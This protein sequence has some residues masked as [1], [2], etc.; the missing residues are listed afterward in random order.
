MFQLKRLAQVPGLVHGI[1][2][3]R[4]GSQSFRYVSH[5]HWTRSNRERFLEQ[6]RKLPGGN[7]LFS[8]G[9][10]VAMRPEFAPPLPVEKEILL[11]SRENRQAGMFTAGDE[12]V[13]EALVTTEPGVFLFLTIADCLPVVLFHPG[14]RILALAHVSRVTAAYRF[15]KDCGE[16][17]ERTPPLLE[18]LIDFLTQRY[19]VPTRDFLA[20]IG[21]GIGKASYA[22]DWFANGNEP[23]WQPFIE[24]KDSKVHV[25][26]AGFSAW[27]L[28]AKGLTPERIEVAGCDTVT[29][30][31]SQTGA[32]QFFSHHRAVRL[33]NEREGRNAFAIGMPIAMK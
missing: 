24:R 1:S 7:P 18:R 15:R 9:N 21:P 2:E 29:A 5:P 33:T 26:L 6:L 16:P 32:Y 22:L 20:A 14:A 8:T 4:D 25:D 23:E 12:I 11:V 30:C 3:L 28:E 10:G 17:T 27:L 31:D 19:G 13:A